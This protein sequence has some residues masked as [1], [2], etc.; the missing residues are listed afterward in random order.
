M[1][2]NK[3]GL[4]DLKKGYHFS[5]ICLMKFKMWFFFLVKLQKWNWKNTKQSRILLI[6]LELKH[7][8]LFWACGRTYY[9]SKI[10]IG[11]R[12]SSAIKNWYWQK[13]LVELSNAFSQ[14]SNT[15][16]SIGFL[17]FCHLSSFVLD[18]EIN[19]KKKTGNNFTHS[20]KYSYFFF[21]NKYFINYP[22]L[23]L[24]IVWVAYWNK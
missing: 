23:I 16:K 15:T 11:T 12:I 17:F 5:P 4:A 6:S 14:D 3:Y 24:A 22:R 10:F 18:G 19:G 8:T 9:Y 1:I 7:W 20:L 2:Q 21:W 13:N